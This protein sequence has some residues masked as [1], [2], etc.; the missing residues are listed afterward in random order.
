M[1]CT[2]KKTLELIVQAGHHY[3]A[4]VKVNQLK[5]YEAIH[6][7]LRRIQAP[8]DRYTWD[9]KSHG[10]S[11]SWQV[12]IYKATAQAKALGWKNLKRF[13]HVQ[14]RSCRGGHWTEHS[15]VYISHVRQ[16]SAQDFYRSIAHRKS[17]ALGQGYHLWRR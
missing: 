16:A 6:R 3:L 7:R 10:R 9:E 12:S 14:R 1:R 15:A 2:P 5:L 8:L 13:I 11:Q 4:Q 17:L